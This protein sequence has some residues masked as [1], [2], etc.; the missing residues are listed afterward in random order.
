M[1]KAAGLAGIVILMMAALDDFNI[2]KITEILNVIYDS[3]DITEV[4][5]S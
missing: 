1:Y 4:P 5:L 2:A 3:G